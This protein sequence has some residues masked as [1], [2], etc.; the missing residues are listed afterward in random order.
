[1]YSIEQKIL[2]DVVHI[3]RDAGIAAPHLLDETA[4]LA[5][6][7]KVRMDA[8]GKL[9]RDEQLPDLRY[10]FTEIAKRVDELGPA[11]KASC[12][13]D[14]LSGAETNAILA[15]LRQLSD[16]SGEKLAKALVGI[17]EKVGHP[18]QMITMETGQL[19]ID[20]C[21][22]Q[23]GD[24]VLS[25]EASI[26]ALVALNVGDTTTMRMRCRSPFAVAVSYLM[27]AKVEVEES[28][29]FKDAPTSSEFVISVP[30]LQASNFSKTSKLKSD[31]LAVLRV[32]RECHSRGIVCVAPSVLFSR[33]AMSIR[34]ELI[35]NN[36]LHAVI[37]LPKGT[38]L[39]TGV[40][41]I[42]LVIDKHREKDDSVA[43]VEVASSQSSEAFDQLTQALKS[44]HEPENGALASSLDI[45]KN[46]YD[47]TISRYKLGQA[48]QELA[49]LENT[50]LLDG[51]ADI[52]RAQSLK[53][54][55]DA[56]DTTAFLEAS[57]RDITESG[58]LVA[59]AKTMHVDKKQLRRAQGQRLYPGDILFTVKGSVGR[60]AFID[61]TCG[62]NWIAGQ[63]FIILRPKLTN[64]PT[65]YLYRYLA[66]HLIQE[67]VQ[68]IATGSA[69]ALLKAADVSGIPV[70][71]PASE[72]LQSVEEV[73]QEILAEYMAIQSHRDTIR[74][75]ELQN[76]SFD[77]EHK[78]EN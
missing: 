43:F 12:L 39:N 64:V 71:L 49:R 30:P 32:A 7:A 47:L 33:A 18:N 3:L 8:G 60:V 27:G 75:L 2:T 36:W 1:M 24:V 45:Q 58:R 70:P 22:P 56:S 51:V 40:A 29:G 5:A 73:H 9:E 44:S 13:L 21:D 10:A 20:L 59:P 16:V 41:P 74:R 46:D 37:G 53:D 65:S 17:A 52:I 26:P 35:N 57:V 62:D 66:S 31:E 15:C 38:L 23:N 61:D 28:V 54:S 42:F 55:E 14:S 78:A 67:Y 50:V 48:T 77:S 19:L 76:W 34:E 11:F 4:L 72:T 69:M 68:E 63:A 25:H 6:W